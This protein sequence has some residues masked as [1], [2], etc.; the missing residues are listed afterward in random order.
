MIAENSVSYL[1]LNR[2]AYNFSI[3]EEE[4]I[5]SIYAKN[6]DRI[7]LRIYNEAHELAYATFLRVEKGTI[8][9]PIILTNYSTETYTVRLKSQ[10]EFRELTLTF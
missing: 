1:L 9:I 7:E 4:L 10:N 2:N 6:E 3:V 5:L 8:A